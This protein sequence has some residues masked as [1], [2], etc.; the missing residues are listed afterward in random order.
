MIYHDNLYEKFTQT[1]SGEPKSMHRLF[2][3]FI[4]KQQP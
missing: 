3:S 1:Y 4:Y 2:L